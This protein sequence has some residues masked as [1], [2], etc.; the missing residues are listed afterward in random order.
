MTRGSLKTY[1][2]VVNNL[3]GLL[4]NAVAINEMNPRDESTN[5]SII[6]L[7]AG[8]T[9][10]SIVPVRFVVNNKTWKMESYDIL[11]AISKAEIKKEEARISAPGFPIQSDFGT[12]SSISV[13]D[14]LN[15]VKN[16]QEIFSVLSEDVAEKFGYERPYNP[17]L[18]E[19]LRYSFKNTQAE[20]T[21]NQNGNELL[22][23]DTATMQYSLKKTDIAK[24]VADDATLYAQVKSDQDIADAMRIAT[25]LHYS[26]QGATNWEKRYHKMNQRESAGNSL[27][28]RAPINLSH[29]S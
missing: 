20:K 21:L 2:Q 13:A 23:G 6:L 12:S 27:F 24:S 22:N 26:Q 5:Y 8:E 7:G 18:T 19:G 14:L 25:R 1:I 17:K 3:D 9:K 15:L 28:W 10:D 29:L 16:Y 4:R 11:Y